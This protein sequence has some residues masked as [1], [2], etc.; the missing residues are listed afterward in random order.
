MKSKKDL[1]EIKQ[2]YPPG[3]TPEA[4]ESKLI[5]MATDLARK[6][7]ANGTAS[8]QV[9]SHF[10]K[11]GT[12]QAKLEQENLRQEIEL[13][14]AKTDAIKSSQ[15]LE[16]LYADAIRAMRNYNGSIDEESSND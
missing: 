3:R 8:S 12:T 6:Q 14:K 1:K 5:A 7:L 13:R 11:L 4:E 16:Q 10:L 9:I 2:K 15:K